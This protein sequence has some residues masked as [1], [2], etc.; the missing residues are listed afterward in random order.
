MLLNNVGFNMFPQNDK[1]Y[2]IDSNTSK[3]KSGAFS[4]NV[5]GQVGAADKPKMPPE[6]ALKVVMDNM[7]LN[8]EEAKQYLESLYGKPEPP[9]GS[10]FNMMG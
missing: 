7:G 5:D 10:S 8:E 4:N 2:G 1:N 6:E 9:S 3:E